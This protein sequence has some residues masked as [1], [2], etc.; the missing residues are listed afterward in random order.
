MANGYTVDT[1]ISQPGY[2]RAVVRRGEEAT[3]IEPAPSVRIE[4]AQA[5]VE[6]ARRRT[7]CAYLVRQGPHRR[8]LKTDLS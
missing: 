5:S 4:L 7:G 3:K 6:A 8:Y 1:E 2:I